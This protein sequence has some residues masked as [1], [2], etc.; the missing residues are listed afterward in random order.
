MISSMTG[1][2]KGDFS[3]NNI[4]ALTEIRSFN[5][6]F[7][8]LSVRLPKNLAHYEQLVKDLVRK[9]ISRGRINITITIQTEND[10]Y[11]GLKADIE[12]ARAYKRLFLDLKN[13]LD[14]LCL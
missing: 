6:R 9:Y 5:N 14:I 13:N 7:L 8:E 10:V 1:Y 11:H 12:L 4:T 2:G 3:K